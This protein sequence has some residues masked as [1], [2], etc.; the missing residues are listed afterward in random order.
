[1]SKMTK[2]QHRVFLWVE[3]QDDVLFAKK[4][5]KPIF[6]SY[7][8]RVEI[9]QYAQIKAK[10]LQQLILAIHEIGDENIVFADIDHHPC[11]TSKKSYLTYRFKHVPSSLMFIVIQEIEGW[12]L[13]GLNAEMSKKLGMRLLPSTNHITKE[14]FIELK[15]K[16][17]T[18]LTFM[19]KILADYSL[20]QAMKKNQSFHY[21]CKRFPPADPGQ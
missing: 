7:Y 12:F 15:P 19:H 21:L 17:G 14:H 3:G 5:L 10:K 11:V 6:K 1:M 2:K 20:E 8:R 13:A 16:S 4:I 9:R 18:R